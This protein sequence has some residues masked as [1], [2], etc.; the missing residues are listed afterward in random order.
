MKASREHWGELPHKI[1]ELPESWTRRRK[2]AGSTGMNAGTT[3][4]ESL[5]FIDPGPRFW[6]LV[7]E[8]KA[9]RR[10]ATGEGERGELT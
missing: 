5:T 3:S 6:E 8:R 9:S 10:Q 4:V 7:E 2:V 1:F